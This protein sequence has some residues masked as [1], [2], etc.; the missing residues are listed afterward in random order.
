MDSLLEPSE[1]PIRVVRNP[2]ELSEFCETLVRTFLGYKA[3]QAK[4]HWQ[5]TKWNIDEFYK[6]LRNVCQ[7]ND[8]KHLV[9]VHKQQQELVLIRSNNATRK[10]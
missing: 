8:Y 2:T 9:R 6:G 10:F 1:E 5:D 3:V 7:K 4:V